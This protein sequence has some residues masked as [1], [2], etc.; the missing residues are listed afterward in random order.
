MPTKKFDPTEYKNKDTIYVAT[1]GYL[2]IS[3]IYQWSKRRKRYLPKTLGNKF[4]AVKRVNE[5]QITKCFS[6]LNEAKTWKSDT[7]DSV[8][9]DK[10]K[11]LT[12]EEV[13]K[14]FL[15]K[16]KSEV[17]IV[18]Y[19]T[20]I[21]QLK[22]FSCF[23]KMKITEITLRIIDGWLVKM[24]SPDSLTKQKSTR[25]SFQKEL[26]IIKQIFEYYSEY[27]CEDISYASPVKKRHFKDCFPNRQK[28]QEK[29]LRAKRRF[30]SGSEIERFLNT[31]KTTYQ[32]QPLG[33]T[34]YLLALFQ[35]RTGTRIGEV[36]AVH[37]EDIYFDSARVHINRTVCWSRKDRKTFISKTTKNG[38]SRVIPIPQDLV[39]ELK[40][41]FL[42]GGR[43]R[44]LVFSKGDSGQFPFS[45]SSICH[46]YGRCLKIMGS[47]WRGTH[48]GRHSFATDYLE[49]TGNQRALQG[50][51]G[52]QTSRQ[53]DHYAKMTAN[54]LEEGMKSYEMK[55]L[56]SKKV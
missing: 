1:S 53:T 38:L 40:K 34:Y 54:T 9:K 39:M 26:S 42:R 50:M 29:Q 51:L 23:D 2:G 4:Y 41:F 22:Y 14:M 32:K 31:M 28:Y 15:E 33:Y 55:I 16:K 47:E 7:S 25:L 21:K 30:L 24:K 18:T 43:N 37:W 36:A 35:L 27:I 20:Y 3:R 6:S 8:L 10:T 19:E 17:R 49:K 11:N 12:F 48:L 45:Y 5:K 56:K 13:K 52:H 46:R 44:G